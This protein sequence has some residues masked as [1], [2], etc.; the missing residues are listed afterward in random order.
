MGCLGPRFGALSAT[1]GSARSAATEM[2]MADIVRKSL[3]APVG[4]LT[5]ATSST[6]TGRGGDKFQSACWCADG[7]DLSVAETAGAA[8]VTVSKRLLVR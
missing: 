6:P 5:A 3:K 8:F 1:M 7:R 4:A 2:S